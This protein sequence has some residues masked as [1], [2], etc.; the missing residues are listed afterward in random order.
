MFTDRKI[1]PYIQN[2][3]YSAEDLLQ[4]VA[5]MFR[6]AEQTQ[7]Q[8]ALITDHFAHLQETRKRDTDPWFHPSKLASSISDKFN[9][10]EEATKLY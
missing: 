9:D 6:L 1:N 8:M 4:K 2:H 7:S 10:T 3:A 5:E